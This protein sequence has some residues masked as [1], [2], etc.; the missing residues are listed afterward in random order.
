MTHCTL[1]TVL[2]TQGLNNMSTRRFKTH[3]HPNASLI[4]RLLAMVYDSLLVMAVW[5]LVGYIFIAFN[6]GEAVTGPLFN[7]TVFLVTFLFFALFWTKSGQTLGMLAWRLRVE[8][9]QGQPINA[10]QALLRFMA[11]LF[12]ALALGMGYWWMLFDNSNLTW[13]D[14]WSSSRVVQLP[15]A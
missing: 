1:N 7:S 11:A 12:S 15:K 5:M 4:K 2:P 10:K 3:N 6:D 13:H 14:R 8:S 9:D